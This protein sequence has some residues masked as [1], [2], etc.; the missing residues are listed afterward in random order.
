[1]YTPTGY[2][3]IMIYCPVFASQPSATPTPESA[4]ATNKLTERNYCKMLKSKPSRV[5]IILYPSSVDHTMIA[6]KD[7]PPNPTTVFPNITS[8]VQANF[9]T[10]HGRVL[11]PTVKRAILPP[12]EVSSEGMPPAVVEGTPSVSDNE[13]VVCHVQTFKNAMSGPQLYLFADYYSKLG[14]QVVIYDRY[15][16]HEEFIS[17]LVDTMGV[18]Y[19]PFTSIQ[20]ADPDKFTNETAAREGSDFKVFYGRERKTKVKVKVVSKKLH[21]FDVVSQFL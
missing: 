21:S 2:V 12:S 15:G 17:D 19:H 8:Y 16:R 11:I 6:V 13:I 18:I 10:E 4:T 14:F 7:P 9:N 1:M 3:G 20:I 5:E